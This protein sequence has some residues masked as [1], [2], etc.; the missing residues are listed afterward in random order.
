[1]EQIR[2]PDDAKRSP[3]VVIPEKGEPRGSLTHA[4]NLVFPIGLF[5]IAVRFLLLCL[6]TLSGHRKVEA[7]AHVDLGLRPR[8]DDAGKAAAQ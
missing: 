8:D 3:M 4:A 6:L 7:E 1:M 5:I 2:I